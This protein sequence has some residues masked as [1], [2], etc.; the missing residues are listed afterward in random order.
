[1]KKQ[2]LYFA[3]HAIDLIFNFKPRFSLNEI[4]EFWGPLLCC[5]SEV[6]LVRYLKPEKNI[7][8]KVF[9]SSNPNAIHLLEANADKISWLHLSI[10]PNAIHLLKANPHKIDK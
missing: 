10:N 2:K 1:M 5:L 6:R 7:I 8:L 4:D 9:S 3:P